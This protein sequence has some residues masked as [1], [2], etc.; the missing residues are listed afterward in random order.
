MIVPDAFLAGK[1]VDENG[2]SPL[3]ACY[4]I[5]TEGTL[6]GQSGFV[7]IRGDHQ[8]AQDGTFLSPP[9]PPGKYFL[10]FFGMLNL[11][12]S[13][14]KEESSSAKQSRVFDFFYPSAEAI[15]GASPFELRAGESVN[16]VI[17]VAKPTWFNISGRVVGNLPVERDQMV[18]MFQRNMGI[19]EGVGGVG[20]SIDAIGSFAGMLLGGSYSASIHQMTPPEPSGYTRSIQQFGSAV[21]NID[22][23][24]QDLNLRL[25][26]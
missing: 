5:V 18:V 1:L 24:V 23:D 16:L 22:A 17:R 25:E 7:K 12:S 13:A 19:L 20:F 10:R 2:L 3:T 15:S 9:L 8:L 6:H 4:T 14:P 11:P 21:V 26:N